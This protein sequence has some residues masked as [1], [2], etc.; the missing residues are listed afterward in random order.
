M[1][2]S[3]AC[4]SSGSND[5]KDSFLLLSSSVLKDFSGISKL[6]EGFH[7]HW[8]SSD[9]ISQT[10]LDEFDGDRELDGDADDEERISARTGVL[11]IQGG[12]NVT[13]VIQCGSIASFTHFV[14]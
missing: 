14:A 3:K 8:V 5:F 13:G 10:F 9:W 12:T 2:L 4:L 1:R 7:F 11:V 6:S